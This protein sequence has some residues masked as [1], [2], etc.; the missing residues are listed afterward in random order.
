MSVIYHNVSVRYFAS[1]DS[2]IARYTARHLASDAVSRRLSDMLRDG[3]IE[4]GRWLSRESHVGLGHVLELIRGTAEPSLSTMLL[5]VDAL[6]LQSIEQLLGP[7]STRL[8]FHQPLANL[9]A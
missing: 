9:P 4:S 7:S 3:Q 6:E 5:L 2:Q 1:T 8:I